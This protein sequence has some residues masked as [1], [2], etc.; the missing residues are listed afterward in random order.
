[1]ACFSFLVSCANVKKKDRERNSSSLSNKIRGNNNNIASS[2]I[3][4]HAVH[5]SVSK[6]Q[7]RD[8]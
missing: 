8:S 4:P 1:M 7:F 5:V 2:F 6:I 3:F